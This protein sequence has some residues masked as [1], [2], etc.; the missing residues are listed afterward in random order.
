MVFEAVGADQS[1][2][3]ELLIVLVGRADGLALAAVDAVECVAELVVLQDLR[4]TVIVQ[5]YSDFNGCLGYLLPILVDVFA[6]FQERCVQQ[7]QVLGEEFL[8][9]VEGTEVKNQFEV[10]SL[11]DELADVEEDVDVGNGVEAVLAF[12]VI[13]GEGAGFHD[14]EVGLGEKNAG[15]LPSVFHIGD[16]DFAD[17]GA[18]EAVGDG[19][20]VEADFGAVFAGEEVVYHFHEIFFSGGPIDLEVLGLQPF[21][22]GD[23]LG[24]HILDK[25]MACG[26]GT[27][28]DVVNAE[29]R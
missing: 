3:G 23:E 9:L 17:S 6:D 13:K 20:Q 18:V 12:A 29:I 14:A 28:L 4:D 7:F 11:D 15:C 24:F 5:E 25:A 1:D 8:A 16:R 21:F 10:G 26:E 19:R 22:K 2:G 27:G